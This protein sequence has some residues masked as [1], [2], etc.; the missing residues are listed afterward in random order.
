VIHLT[1]IRASRSPQ[2][3]ARAEGRVEPALRT[4]VL[5]FFIFLHVLFVVALKLVPQLSTLH[6]L[7]SLAIV[8]YLVIR[9]YPKAW[10]VAG[11][12]YLVGSEALWRMTGASVF[13][14]FG[15]Y[16]VLLVV[17][18][19]LCLRP[20]RATSRLPVVYLALLAPSALL[21][22]VSVWNLREL[23]Q[24]LSSELSGPMAYAA[25]CLYLLGGTLSR[26]DV[27]RCLV[28]MLAPIASVAAVTF[29]AVRATEIQFGASSN[30]AAS[31][32]FGPNQVAA[33]L[34]L[35]MVLCFLLLTG[36]IGGMFWKGMLASLL[37]WFGI[38]AALTFSRSGLY[39]AVAAMLAGTAF[40]VADVRRFGAVVLT[41]LAL[42]GLGKFVIAPRLNAFTGGAIEDRF[43]RTDLSGRGDL[44]RGDLIVFL[45]NPV[46]GVGV[47]MSRQA[48]N[49]YLDRSAKSHT[50][51]TRL[52]SEHGILGVAALALMLLM[53]IQCVRLQTPGWPK[54][55][56]A[57]IVAFALI[58]MTGS[59]MR[60]AIPSFLLAFA[61]VRI[62]TQPVGLARAARA[63][64]PRWKTRRRGLRFTGAMPQ[65][66]GRS[67]CL[68][69]KLPG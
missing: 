4:S 7:T 46:L 30:D 49:E 35:G 51:F 18:A 26:K 20:Q 42:L 39:Y 1:A 8:L 45:H 53:S 12:A 13:Y 56:S 10:V 9:R 47:G 37:V 59:G 69:E 11:C 29:F 5:S 34:G 25:C 24:I 6:A 23:R 67:S 38:Q 57:S 15:K 32:G 68:T 33:A 22:I 14:E 31:G 50:E 44:M 41:V 64:R 3:F 27:L 16:A 40:L 21:T 55:F 28:V 19:A 63:D 43:A 17:V 52:L 60:L 2:P 54:V 48:R 58:F 65:K 36:R 61:G 62:V 66:Q